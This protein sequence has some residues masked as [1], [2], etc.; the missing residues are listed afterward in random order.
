VSSLDEV[1]IGKA[2]QH[3]LARIL[4]I[5]KQAYLAEAAIYEDWSL[6]PLRQTQQEIETEFESKVFLKAQIADAL[7]G[8]VRMHLTASTCMIGRLVVDPHYQRRGIGSAL[9]LQAESVFSDADRFE[10]F[11]GTK[12]TA[13]IRLYER[14]GYIAYREEALSPTVTLIYMQKSTAGRSATARVTNC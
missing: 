7:V 13:N 1:L 9:L 11:T 6:P 5:Q 3:D 4:A 14:H 10:L 2:G 8:S 12:S